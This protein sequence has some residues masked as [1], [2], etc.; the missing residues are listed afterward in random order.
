MRGF[1][2]V[3][4]ALLGAVCGYPAP[5]RVRTVH[6]TDK[7]MRAHKGTVG[8]DSGDTKCN[9]LKRSTEDRFYTKCRYLIGV[10]EAGTGAVAGPIVAAAVCVLPGLMDPDL[11]HVRDSKLLSASQREATYAAMNE[12]S[13]ILRCVAVVQAGQVDRV[14]VAAATMCAIAACIQGMADMLSEG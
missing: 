10:D 8:T 6:A 12:D 4:W 5:S 9:D 13:R 7:L 14:G 3:L 11:P 2:L 1:A